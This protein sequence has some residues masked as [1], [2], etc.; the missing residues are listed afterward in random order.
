M[1][2]NTPDQRI[3]KFRKGQTALSE[4]HLNSIVDGVNRL[5]GINAPTQKQPRGK[6]G[7]SSVDVM[8]FVAQFGDY[9]QCENAALET[10]Y[11][12]KPYE[13]RRTPFDTE[14]INGVTYTYTSDDERE[15]V[16]GFDTETQFI[17]PS[18]RVGSEIYATMPQ[19]GTGVVTEGGS[20]VAVTYLEMN[21]GRA[22]AYDPDA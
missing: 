5:S 15:A 2:R 13:L 4:R 1:P 16:G 14:T 3:N 19:G 7:G 10:V 17:T 12:A 6:S 9:L 18:Y 22:W 20:P 21:Q 11:I 8:T